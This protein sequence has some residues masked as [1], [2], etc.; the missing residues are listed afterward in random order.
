MNSSSSS[1]FSNNPRTNGLCSSCY[2]KE[3][4]LA[5]SSTTS[6]TNSTTSSSSSSSSPPPPPTKSGVKRSIDHKTP[7]KET[8][9]TTITTTPSSPTTATPT[10]TSTTV[11]SPISI[12]TTPT[13]ET[14][15]ASNSPTLSGSPSSSNE[16]SKCKFKGCG[17]FIGII[18]SATKCRCGEVYCGKHIHNHNCTFDYKAMAKSSIAKA[19]PQILANKIVKL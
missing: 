5:P 17:K 2:Q 15:G 1:N 19:N 10:T 7:T 16:N 14:T 8:T 4:K 13:K 11:S 18:A 3:I 12:P 6:S 9:N